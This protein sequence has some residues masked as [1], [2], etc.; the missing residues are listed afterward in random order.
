MTAP[1]VPGLTDLLR[2]CLHLETRCK[3]KE[4]Q[5]LGEGKPEDG[6]GAEGGWV[7]GGMC[8]RDDL[9]YWLKVEVGIAMQQAKRLNVAGMSIAQSAASFLSDLTEDQ[10]P[11][12]SP[13]VFLSEFSNNGNGCSYKLP[14]ACQ[15]DIVQH[16]NL[17]KRPTPCTGFISLTLARSPKDHLS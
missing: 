4:N 14:L 6:R 17:T 8:S 11:T 15:E 12:W 9:A 16:L 10:L 13:F 1:K 5:E 2:T 3:E 7:W